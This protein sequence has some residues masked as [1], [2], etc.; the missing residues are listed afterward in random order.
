MCCLQQELEKISEAL[1]I[2]GSKSLGP[3]AKV[4]LVAKLS[5]PV[6]PAEDLNCVPVISYMIGKSLFSWCLAHFTY[7][8]D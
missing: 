2:P 8:F 6:S 4:H 1:R 7:F 3:V 5:L